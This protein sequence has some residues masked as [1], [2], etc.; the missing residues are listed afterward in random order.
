MPLFTTI[1]I[2]QLFLFGRREDISCETLMNQSQK[3]RRPLRAE[4]RWRRR[5]ERRRRR[6]L[7]R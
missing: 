4:R 3:R 1:L 2:G 5:R 6:V 7:G